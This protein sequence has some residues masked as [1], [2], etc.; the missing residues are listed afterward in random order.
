MRH[1]RS[2]RRK[3]PVGIVSGVLID[4]NAG[5]NQFCPDYGFG[6]VFAV[7]GAA[8]AGACRD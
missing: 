6:G 3:L 2:T 5:T 1:S 7:F 8:V 4:L